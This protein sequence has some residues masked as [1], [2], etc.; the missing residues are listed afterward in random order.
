[1]EQETKFGNNENHM[2]NDTTEKDNVKQLVDA[3]DKKVTSQPDAG[4]DKQNAAKDVGSSGVEMPK[5]EKVDKGRT[6]VNGYEAS[7]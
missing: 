5:T 2:A 3:D 7:A 6:A 4:G 1:M